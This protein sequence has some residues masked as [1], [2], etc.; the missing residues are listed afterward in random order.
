VYASP[1]RSPPPPAPGGPRPA[2][3]AGNVTVVKYRSTSSRS[4]GGNGHPPGADSYQSDNASPVN[5][6]IVRENCRPNARLPSGHTNASSSGMQVR[7]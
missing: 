1:A 4:P 3:G 2:A 6:S 5:R 7:V